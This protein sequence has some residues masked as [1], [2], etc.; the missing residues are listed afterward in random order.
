MFSDLKDLEQGLV[1]CVL[2][3]YNVVLENTFAI[4]AM[5]L[6]HL[7]CHLCYIFLKVITSLKAKE[8]DLFW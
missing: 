1:R 3:L 4:S 7:L 5:S 8:S 6:C 2:L